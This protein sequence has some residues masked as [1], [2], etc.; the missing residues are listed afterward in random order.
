M[1]SPRSSPALV[2]CALLASCSGGG[3]RGGLA[4]EE[5]PP[6]A[7][8]TFAPAQGPAPLLVDFT[9][10]STGE[11]ISWA[12][13]FGDGASSAEQHPSHVYT[14][15]GTFSVTL[16]VT[17]ALGTDSESDDD[18][19]TVDATPCLISGA[20]QVTIVAD[21]PYGPLSGSCGN[22]APCLD[23][24]LP[25]DPPPCAP[26]LLWIHGGGWNAGSKSESFTVDLANSIAASG[27]PVVAI[28]YALATFEPC[29]TG[30][31]AG[32]YPMMIQDAKL[33]L[34]WVHRQGT[35]LYGLPDVVVVGG[36]S[37]GGYLAAMLATTASAGEDFFDPDPQG[38]YRVD[39]AILFSAPLNLVTIGCV[40]NP[41]SASCTSACPPPPD[42]F[43][44]CEPA[45]GCF[46]PG[47]YPPGFPCILAP[48]ICTNYDAPETYLGEAWPE[49]GVPL[50]VDCTDPLALPPGATGMPTLVDWYDASPCF[51][52]QGGEPPF[53]IFHAECD[54]IV[55][56]YGATDFTDR[57]LA[58]GASASLVI[59]PASSLCGQ[60]CQHGGAGVYG[61]TGVAAL[62]LGVLRTAYET[63]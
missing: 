52:I 44:F 16:A 53:D 6:V 27:V 26:T 59:E 1:H 18:A 28:D 19:I 62:I 37:S 35:L 29:G 21:V 45:T 24:Y 12:W 31:G 34:D 39:R 22:G 11:P 60:G 25:Q 47:G 63:P 41:W 57:L 48:D 46:F 5:D 54:G 32:S 2:L 10:T 4:G 58:F 9:D 15:A 14:Q 42:V 49:P 23:L 33:A 8:F 51:W 20:F 55:P 50:G 56:S 40:G 17:N 38:D 7:G 30:L 43:P 61:T 3:K 13:E 36:S